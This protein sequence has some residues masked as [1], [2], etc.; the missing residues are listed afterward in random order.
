MAI[1]AFNSCE[2]TGAKKLAD[3]IDVALDDMKELFA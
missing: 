2:E 1:T 3:A